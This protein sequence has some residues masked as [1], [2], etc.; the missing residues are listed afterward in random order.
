MSRA[1]FRAKSGAPAAI[2]D[3]VGTEEIKSAGFA[4]RV[5]SKMADARSESWFW[6]P[7][8]AGAGAG[9]ESG[10]DFAAQQGILQPCWQQARV[11]LAHAGGVCASSNGV[12]ASRKLQMMAS[13][14]FMF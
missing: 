12:P 10:D 2:K 6:L 7:V 13:A 11:C 8:F 14:I 1:Q 5:Q 4:G 9:C 3:G